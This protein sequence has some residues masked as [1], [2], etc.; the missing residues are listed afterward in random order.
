MPKL[1]VLTLTKQKKLKQMAAKLCEGSD[2]KVDDIPPA[3]NV[4]KV[5]LLVIGISPR[6]ADT[7]VMRFFGALDP[8]RAANVA[9]FTDAAPEALTKIIDACKEGGVNV[10]D[11][12]LTV[13]CGLFS[14][15][16]AEDLQQICRWEQNIESTLG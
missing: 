12:I 16:S 2:V 14:S 5:K 9:F 1:R 15:A 8:A 4:E 3:Y 6:L 10:I 13:K 7:N 11:D